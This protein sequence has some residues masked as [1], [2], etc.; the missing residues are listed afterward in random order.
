LQKN[1]RLKILLAAAVLALPA[2]EDTILDATT[3]VD[4]TVVDETT[5]Q[6]LDSAR[7]VLYEDNEGPLM[8]S[9]PIQEMTTDKSGRFRFSFEWKEEPYTIKVTRRAYK[10]LRVEKSRLT[11]QQLVFDYH[12]LE[13]LKKKQTLTFDMEAL[14]TLQVQLINEAP[15]N[16]P[17][18]LTLHISNLNRQNLPLGPLTFTGITNEALPAISIAGNRYVRF[19]Y[20]VTEAGL[21]RDFKDSVFVLPFRKNV[22]TLKY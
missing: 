12:T 16:S 9:H 8:G 19:T 11:G 5:G 7:V 1:I 4:G 6:P 2:C 21:R 20:S 14:G 17:D 18:S 22:Y 15:A 10:Y 13:S 3:Q